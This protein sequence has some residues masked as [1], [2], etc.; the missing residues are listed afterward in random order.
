M[1]EQDFF[2]DEEETAEA[3]TKETAKPSTKSGSTPAPAARKSAAKP[4]TPK[5]TGG[6]GSFFE[7]QVSITIASL[8][9][10]IGLLIGVIVGFLV[11]PDGGTVTTATPTATATDSEATAPQ[12]TDEQL[13]S[14]TLPEGHPDISSMSTTDTTGQ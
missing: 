5:P 9:T 10:V 7:Q 3:S 2:F 13:S 11:A 1:S 12:L 8:M 6:S 4:A 14:G